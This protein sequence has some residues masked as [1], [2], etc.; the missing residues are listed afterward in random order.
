MKDR[1]LVLSVALV[2]GF[3]MVVFAHGCYRDS[4][5]DEMHGPECWLC[6]AYRWSHMEDAAFQTRELRR[7][8]GDK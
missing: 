1:A 8:G 3:L 4:I 7:R 5:V 6:N 2:V